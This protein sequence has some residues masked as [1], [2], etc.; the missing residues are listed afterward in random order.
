MKKSS[1]RPAHEK[2]TDE[3]FMAI[4]LRLSQ[5]GLGH[6]EP[7]P[8]VGAVV[9][10][11]GTMLASGHHCAFGAEHAEVMALKNVNIPG[12]TLYLTLEPCCHFG[13]TPPCTEL[14]IAKKVRRVV[15]AMLDPNPLVNGRGRARLRSCGIQTHCGLFADWAAQI[16]RHYLRAMQAKMPYVTIH[17]GISLDGKLTDKNGRSQ[18]MTSAELRLIAHSLRGEFSAVLAGHGT[19]TADDPLLTLRE[20]SWQGKT[21]YRVVL[22]TQNSLSR[23]LKVFSE[24]ERFPL[25]IFSSKKAADQG[26]KVAHHYFV[27]TVG[28]GLDWNEI[29]GTLHQL[30]IASVLVEGG[31]KVIDSLIREKRF[32][33]IVLFTSRQ[34]VGGRTS[35]PL[36]ASGCAGLD[37][38]P[39]LARWERIEL[40][41]GTI[42]RGFPSCSPA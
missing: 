41:S 18:W 35:S 31:G 11:N 20:A 30:G 28:S 5:Q 39:S 15:M 21:L 27:G 24:Q 29:L 13:K 17:A 32:D 40:A 4:A 14:I 36:F 42:M 7:N 33:E 38:A 26:K 22:D 23:R 25:I 37:Q 8:L 2:M 3:K 16:N 9:V 1:Q 19:V 6:T 34:L 10:K 12:T